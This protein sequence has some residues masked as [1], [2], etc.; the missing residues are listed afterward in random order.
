MEVPLISIIVRHSEG[1]KYEGDRFYKRCDCKKWLEYFHSGK[2]QRVAAK[3]RSWAIAEEVK[4]TLEEQFKNGVTAPAVVPASTGRA[5]VKEK[6]ALFITGKEGENVSVAVL[7]KYRY[8]LP[9]F[10]AFLSKRSNFYP[11]DITLDDLVEYRATWADLAKI[12]QQKMQ[13]RLRAF[14]KFACPKDNL[15]DLLKLK[16]IRIKAADRP[17]PQPFTDAELNR[18]LAQVSVTFHDEPRR[19]RVI[20]LIHLMVSTGLAIVDAVKLEKKNFEGGWL[21]IIRQKTE[22]PVRQKLPTTLLNELRTVTNGN[23]RFVFWN[24]DIKLSSLTGL[25]QTNLREVMKAANVYTHGDLSHRFRDSY[26]KFL[27]DN[28]CSTT[29]VADA[30]GDTEA[31]VVKHYR[32]L[33]PDDQLS[34]LPQRHFSAQA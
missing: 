12:T 5:T 22:R 1:C 7:R 28:G 23:P 19:S 33:V 31:I 16:G 13:E 27:F 14:L 17:K 2:Q 10:E 30:I 21:N 20:A 24:G 4:R 34:K 18:L 32:S 9:R 15:F 11:S 29:Q 25:F 6:V 8:E 26:V 3:T